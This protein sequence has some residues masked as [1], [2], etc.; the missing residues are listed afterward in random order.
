MVK[1]EEEEN[2]YALEE[3]III[4]KGMCIG[5]KESF[6]IYIYIMNHHNNNDGNGK[7]LLCF[8][9]LVC[10]RDKWVMVWVIIELDN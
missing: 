8:I 5:W 9:G 7:N 2:V 6:G 10:T 1:K 4:K 3:R